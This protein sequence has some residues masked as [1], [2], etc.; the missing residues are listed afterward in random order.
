MIRPASRPRAGDRRRGVLAHPRLER[1]RYLRALRRRRRR[2][3]APRRRTTRGACRAAA[4]RRPAR[5]D[6]AHRG[7]RLRRHGDRPPL[8]DDGRAGGLQA[9]RLGARLGRARGA[10]RGGAVDHRRR[11]VHSA[12]GQRAHHAG[13]R[14]EDRHPARQG[15]R[16]R[17]PA[18]EHVGRV[19]SARTRHGG[20]RRAHPRRAERADG[21]RRRRLH[22]GRGAGPDGRRSAIARRRVRSGEIDR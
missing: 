22:L 21:G 6:P 13:C 17:R 5:V 3:R 16:H 18:R 4:R 9:R 20:A 8:P 10:G 12:P 19:D 14:E 15:G 7:Q 11:L 2:G 1:P